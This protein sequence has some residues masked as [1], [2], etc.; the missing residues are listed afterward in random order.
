MSFIRSNCRLNQLKNTDAR[1][2]FQVY[3][4]ERTA[5]APAAM[6]TKM[7]TKKPSCAWHKTVLKGGRIG[8]ADKPMEMTHYAL[9]GNRPPALIEFFKDGDDLANHLRVFA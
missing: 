3:F 2:Y 4:L 7:S 5:A 6:K 9:A 1:V 8:A